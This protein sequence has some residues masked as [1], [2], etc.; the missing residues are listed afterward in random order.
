M[1]DHLRIRDLKVGFQTFDG[2]VEILDIGDIHIEKG[3]AYGLVGESGAG[4]TVLALAILGLLRQPPA[5]VKAEE[6]S[7]D[8]EPLLDKSQKELREIR[9]R[10]ISMI[11]QDPMSALDPAF[12][13]GY[14]L[15]EVI[16]LRNK[17]DR[18]EAREKALEFMRMVELPDP[19]MMLDKYPHQLSGGQRQRI[20]IALALACGSQFLIADEPTRNLDVTVQASV[21]KTIH[22]LR[23]ELGVSLLFIANNLSLV[24]VMCNRVG[25]LLKGR[26]VETGRVRDILD[27]PLHPY[28]L[29]LLRAV[30]SKEEQ[31]DED[32]IKRD[33]EIADPSRSR[34]A[35]YPRCKFR[36]PACEGDTAFELV[37]VSPTHSVACPYALQSLAAASGA[38][39]T[40]GATTA[41]DAVAAADTHG[42]DQRG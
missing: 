36:G 12:D 40:A 5:E 31:L 1:A 39:A 6:L 9:G 2:F 4:K 30:P 8:G 27:D 7:L 19:E 16:R 18:K 42:G 13:V 38:L 21:L 23:E 28:T 10:R 20:V 26:I 11:L 32:E 25:I 41:S 3:E 24:S 29:D 14:Q 34:C 15:S 37:S 22:R 35:L 17:M 33:V